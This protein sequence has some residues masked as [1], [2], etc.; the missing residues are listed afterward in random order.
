M[1]KI[2]KMNNNTEDFNED[3]GEHENYSHLDSSN[4]GTL[5]QNTISP[6]VESRNEEKKR[7]EAMKNAQLELMMSRIENL[8]HYTTPIVIPATTEQM[9]S[10]TSTSS[11]TSNNTN[12]PPLTTFITNTGSGQGQNQLQQM[13]QM[14]QSVQSYSQGQSNY[15]NQGQGYNQGQGQFAQTPYTPP[16]VIRIQEITD[17]RFSIKQYTDKSFV[18]RPGPAVPQDFFR[19]Y[20]SYLSRPDLSGSFNPK[21]KD[22]GIPGWCYSNYSYNKVLEIVR[23]IFGGALLPQPVQHTPQ[24]QGQQ[25]YQQ[26]YQQRPTMNSILPTNT[27]VNQSSINQPAIG[28]NQSLINQSPISQQQ[29]SIA[30]AVA[31]ADNKQRIVIEVVKPILGTALNLKIADQVLPILV[32]VVDPMENGLVV[33]AQADMQNGGRIQL[34]LINYK[35]QIPGYA[36]PHEI[37]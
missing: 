32:R 27:A 37:Y 28:Q 35:W 31:L 23:G 17:S 8:K 13:N 15:Q 6:E 21:L 24:E 12:Q 3:E 34:K 7:E 9:N 11:A 16:S 20:S 5:H 22:G 10:A 19:A 18:L 4:I 25:S 30:P 36:A 14:S 26:N 33:S 2:A 29:V 1:N